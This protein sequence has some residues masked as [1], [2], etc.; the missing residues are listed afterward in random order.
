MVYHEAWFKDLNSIKLLVRALLRLYG[1]TRIGGR[2]AIAGWELYVST[3]QSR[4]KIE[5][6]VIMAIFKAVISLA[7]LYAIAHL[8]IRSYKAV[9]AKLETK[10]PG[11][12]QRWSFKLLKVAFILVLVMLF[13]FVVIAAEEIFG[14]EI[15]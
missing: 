7:V 1:E 11:F 12:K 2:K 5:V 15:L 10:Y 8:F 14:I 13:V 9:T 6:A 4:S 3:Q